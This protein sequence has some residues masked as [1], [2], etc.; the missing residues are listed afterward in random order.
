MV[1]ILVNS[2]GYL[3]YR[4]RY[5]GHCVSSPSCCSPHSRHWETGGWHRSCST[6]ISTSTSLTTPLSQHWGNRHKQ[7]IIYKKKYLH[8]LD[9]RY[10]I[11]YEVWGPL[12]LSSPPNEQNLTWAMRIF[13][14]SQLTLHCNVTPNLIR[15]CHVMSCL[16][17][18]GG[19]QEFMWWVVV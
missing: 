9:M 6:F 8:S 12:V 18:S 13:K 17:G 10:K 11:R 15:T 5:S 3:M 2:D 19:R 14:V 1:N 4:Y 16:G 7:Q